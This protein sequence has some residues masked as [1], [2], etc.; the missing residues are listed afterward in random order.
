[1]KRVGVLLLAIICCLCNV[2]CQ[3][4]DEILI[5]DLREFPATYTRI[6]DNIKIELDIIIDETAEKFLYNSKARRI[7]IN[8][9]KL[10]EDLIYKNQ[11]QDQIEKIDDWTYESENGAT[12][13]IIND[14]VAFLSNSESYKV[15]Q[16]ELEK[17][18]LKKT[19]DKKVDEK[20]FELSPGRL[21]LEKQLDSWGIENF[22]LDNRSYVNNLKIKSSQWYGYEKWQGLDVFTNKYYRSLSEKAAP[23][24][25]IEVSD[26]I[27]KLQLLYS[28]KFIEGEEILKLQTFDKVADSM[29]EE[30]SMLLTDNKYE[31]VRAKLAFWVKDVHDQEVLDMEPVWVVTIQEYKEGNNSGY[32]EYEEIYSAVTAHN[33]G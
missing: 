17:N 2:S 4:S 15:A 14:S 31:A 3:K 16:K 8:E 19:Q 28:Y 27:E 5:S 24:Q 7:E 9:E 10:V 11:S 25:I 1:M 26:K 29:E 6:S 32:V 20:S 22:F 12:L 33:I 30:Y 21:E 18:S 13:A 23:L